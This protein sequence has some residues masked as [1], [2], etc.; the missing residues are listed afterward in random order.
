MSESQSPSKPDSSKRLADEIIALKQAHMRGDRSVCARV[1][2]FSSRYS[3]A[4]DEVILAASMI[5]AHGIVSREHGFQ[6]WLAV[7]EANIGHKFLR[8]DASLEHLRKQAKK[9]LK[10]YHA[11]D[12]SAVERVRVHWSADEFTL[13][14]AQFLLAREYGFASWPKLVASLETPEGTMVM[15]RPQ[16]F[17]IEDMHDEIGDRLGEVF[18]R[19]LGE[20]AECYTAF[21]DQTTYAEFIAAL[22]RPGCL[23]TFTMESMQSRSVLDI[24]MPLALAL[25]GKEP[26]D[27]GWLTEEEKDRMAP[28]FHDILAELQRAW[29]P[30]RPTIFG[31]VQISTDPRLVTVTEPDA[32]VILVGLQIASVQHSGLIPVAYPLPGGIYELREH[33]DRK[34]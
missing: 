8:G 12:P 11:G 25:L 6:S 21:L 31:N 1:R 26:D 34:N 10:A 3:N 15:S 2:K 20:R 16:L 14:D 33:F 28:V 9:L 23:C 24:A 22:A 7:H 30:V 32:L 13:N 19:H 4:S 29:E 5:D 17:S 18:S 27:E